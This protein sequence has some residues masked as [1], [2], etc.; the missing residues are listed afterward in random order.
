MSKGSLLVLG[1][2]IE[3]KK[4]TRRS[5]VQVVMNLENNRHESWDQR[6]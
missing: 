2:R 3:V 6:F 1:L 4:I 5:R